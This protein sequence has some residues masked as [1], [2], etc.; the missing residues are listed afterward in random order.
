[1]SA[2]VQLHLMTV[3]AFLSWRAPDSS[4]RWQLIDGI[5]CAMAPPSGRHA[6]I[7]GEA[8][9]LIGNHLAEHRP[10]CRVAIGAGVSPGPFNVRI[11]DLSVSCTPR[12]EDDRLL[13]DPVLIV[14]VLSPSNEAQTWANIAQYETIPS[15][16]EVLVLHA[17][18]V[19]AE[20]LRRGDAGGWPDQSEH[21]LSG[22]EV[23]LASLGFAVLVDAF[24]RT[25]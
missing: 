12:T 15:V 11:P 13:P 21:V 3:D 14:E 24:Y 2:A 17:A 10:E 18:E 9:R 1:M 25:A 6:A 20:I 4:K 23:R 7:H 5:P 16:L 22:G 19:H 8:T